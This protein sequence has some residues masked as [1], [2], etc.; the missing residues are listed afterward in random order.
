M[1]IIYSS[2]FIYFMQLPCVFLREGCL[3]GNLIIINCDDNKESGLLSEDDAFD[4]QKALP[5]FESAV[6]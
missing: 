6:E 3:Y 1:L 2:I 4:T 5:H